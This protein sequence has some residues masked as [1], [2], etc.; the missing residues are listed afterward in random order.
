MFWVVGG[1]LLFYGLIIRAKWTVV[2][3]RDYKGQLITH[4]VYQRVRHTRF[5]LGVLIA[6]GSSFF[7]ISMMAFLFSVVYLLFAL[8]EIIKEENY[9]VKQDGYAYRGYMKRVKW[10]LIPKVW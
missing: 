6:F 3:F 7:F 5:Y 4:G 8:I 2:W 9:L 1:I 10:R